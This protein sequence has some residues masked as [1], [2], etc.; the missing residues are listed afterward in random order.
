MSENFKSCSVNRILNIYVDEREL[1]G[2]LQDEG[3]V[4]V[5]FAQ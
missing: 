1:L 3:K 4:R 2:E 5:L